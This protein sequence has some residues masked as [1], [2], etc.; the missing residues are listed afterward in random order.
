[1]GLRRGYARRYERVSLLLTECCLSGSVVVPHRYSYA[2]A[3][4]NRSSFCL[5]VEGG[6]VHV[7]GMGLTLCRRGPS[8]TIF[9]CS[10]QFVCFSLVMSK[11]YWRRLFSLVSSYSFYLDV[12]LS[13]PMMLQFL[14]NFFREY[15]SSSL[16]D[17][18]VLQNLTPLRVLVSNP[19]FDISLTFSFPIHRY[20]PRYYPTTK[21]WH[22]MYIYYTSCNFT[23]FASSFYTIPNVIIDTNH[24]LNA[25][26]EDPQ[27]SMPI[28]RCIGSNDFPG[29]V[30]CLDHFLR[31]STMQFNI[32]LSFSCYRN[33]TYAKA[34]SPS[35]PG[36]PRYVS[37]LRH[38]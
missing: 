21:L 11:D 31:C 19:H 7:I 18:G 6:T 32:W 29:L 22:F 9:S 13:S 1:M 2:V 15:T 16:E 3:C 36:S 4:P 38:R 23:V 14:L 30:Q 27:C 17:G 12:L 33:K 34:L 35:R 20:P 28:L 5:R 8:Q 10:E 26:S 37:S 24:L 25:C